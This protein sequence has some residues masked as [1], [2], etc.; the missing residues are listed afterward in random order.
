MQT[1]PFYSFHHVNA[2]ET[3]GGGRVAL[4]TIAWDHVDLNVNQYTVGEDHYSGAVRMHTLW[5]PTAMQM[6]A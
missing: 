1:K 5:E 6:E 2:F 3:H 4:D